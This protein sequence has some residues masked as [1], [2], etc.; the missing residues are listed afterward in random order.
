MEQL[1][2]FLKDCQHHAYW[3][4]TD[5]LLV[6]VSG[7]VDSMVLVDLIHHLPATLKPWFGV[8][9]VNH[10]LREVSDE[11]EAF[12]KNYCQEKKIPF[13]C[14]Q[15]KRADHPA[16]GEEAAARNFRYTFFQEM[17]VAHKA[18]HLVTAHHGDDQVETI[19]MR[20]VRGGQLGNMAGIRT[21]RT[22]GS[23]KLVRPLLKY[24]KEELYAYSRQHRLRYYEDESNTSLKYTR[25]RY[26]QTIVPLLKQENPKVLN[27]FNDFSEDL[28]DVLHLSEQLIQEK[29]NRVT[30]EAKPG[31]WKLT[32]PVFLSYEPALQRQ[33]LMRL[34]VKVFNADPIDS[35]RQQTNEVI[36]LMVNA[37]PNSQLNL[38]N[39]WRVRREYEQLMIEKPPMVLPVQKNQEQKLVPEQWTTL[40]NGG[41]IGLFRVAAHA[42]PPDQGHQHIWLDPEEV[43]LPLTIRHRK[44]GDRMSLKGMETGH[45]KIKSIFI[46]QKIPLK[47]RDEVYLITDATNE[48]IWLVEYKESRLSIQRETDKIQYILIYQR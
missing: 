17:M 36:A 37:K 29:I 20:L 42:E 19:L 32:I 13:F 5:R 27:H 25:N 16:T 2:G 47:Q 26:R 6:A 1:S 23:G 40:A 12:L 9:H 15:W 43:V 14:T 44:P 28:L 31:F 24:S 34:L 22:F 18:T 3:K 4:P 7:G 33:I 48:I 30:I 35:L 8:V 11:E 10:K 46:D 41:Q 45:K 38:P 39:G 21:V